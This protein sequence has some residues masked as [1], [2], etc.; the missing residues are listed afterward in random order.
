MLQPK[1]PFFDHV[2]ITVYPNCLGCVLDVVS[3]KDQPPGVGKLI[4]DDLLPDRNRVAARIGGGVSDDQ[5]PLE[6][7]LEF[8]IFGIV[9][10]GLHQ[11]THMSIQPISCGGRLYVVVVD[12]DR[13]SPLA[14]P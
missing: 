7:V 1:K 3:N 10:G 9:L 2:F 8:S 6:L 12:V 13:D 4:G 11:L 14:H 5:I